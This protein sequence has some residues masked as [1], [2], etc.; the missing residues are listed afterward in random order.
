[1]RSSPG[2]GRTAINIK[3]EA[4]GK[5]GIH[6]YQGGTSFDGSRS[7][8]RRGRSSPAKVIQLIQSLPEG[9]ERSC[10]ECQPRSNTKR[11]TA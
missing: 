9:I 3:K 6:M 5:F 11:F 10:L 2:D 7:S 4:T 8:G 1:M